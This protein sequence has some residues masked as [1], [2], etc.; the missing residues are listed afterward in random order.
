MR[1][2]GEASESGKK[3]SATRARETFLVERRK[4][5]VARP[6]VCFSGV[7]LKRSSPVTRHGIFC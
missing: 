2:S 7:S 1:T 5:K 4:R 6:L 3:T